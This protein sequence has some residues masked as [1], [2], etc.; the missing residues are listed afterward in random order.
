MASI[1][2]IS[3][4]FNSVFYV[5]PKLINISKEFLIHRAK[6]IIH[7]LLTNYTYPNLDLKISN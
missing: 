5:D 3:N 2:E 4:A 1:F 6:F 7:P